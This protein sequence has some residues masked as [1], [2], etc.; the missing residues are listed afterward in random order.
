MKKSAEAVH[1]ILADMTDRRGLRQ[2]WEQIDPD[3]QAE[4]RETWTEIV[5]SVFT[6]GETP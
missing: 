6:N 5:E 4:I 2:E 3:I 1:K